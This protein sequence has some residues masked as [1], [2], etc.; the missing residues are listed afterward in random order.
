[1]SWILLV[2]VLVVV[3]FIRLIN[4]LF[5]MF[6]LLCSVFDEEFKLVFLNI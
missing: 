6:F 3:G 4:K 5:L 1:M 2:F